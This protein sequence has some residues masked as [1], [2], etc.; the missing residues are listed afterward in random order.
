MSLHIPDVR[1]HDCDAQPSLGVTLLDRPQK[2]GSQIVLLLECVVS[3]QR[4][5]HA[6]RLHILC[7]LETPVKMPSTNVFYFAAIGEPFPGIL[8]DGLQKTEPNLLWSPVLDDHKR[9]VQQL[10]HQSE[11]LGF[12]DVVAASHLLR[13]GECPAPP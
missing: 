7:E 2:R 4:M 12:C 8:A 6:W 9:L 13:S 5:V 11:H 1:K 3:M 10:L